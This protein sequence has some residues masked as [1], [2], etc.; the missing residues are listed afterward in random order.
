MEEE[1]DV[2]TQEPVIDESPP[3]RPD[4]NLNIPLLPPGPPQQPH[5]VK[6]AVSSG[7]R[8]FMKLVVKARKIRQRRAR[9]L[10][11]KA[12]TKPGTGA[13]MS[14]RPNRHVSKRKVIIK[15]SK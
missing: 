5:G 7:K 4:A 12:T 2:D 11:E 13:H 9:K 14:P 10:R 15:G 6:R 3:G 8:L 1:K